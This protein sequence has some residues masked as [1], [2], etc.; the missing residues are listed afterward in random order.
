M[1]ALVTDGI[2]EGTSRK[3]SFSIFLEAGLVA[4][5]V[6]P[7]APCMDE[8]YETRS[9]TF[10]VLFGECRTVGVS[11]ERFM[12]VLLEPRCFCE[13]EFECLEILIHVKV[14]LRS[15][16]RADDV[17]KCGRRMLPFILARG[18]HI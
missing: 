15:F 10:T 5:A 3:P 14:R 9:T 11:D 1:V 12:A 17:E 18:E 8:D 6:R 13:G 7:V 2:F 4:A 16:G